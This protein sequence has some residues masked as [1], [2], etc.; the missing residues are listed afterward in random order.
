MTQAMKWRALRMFGG[1]LCW[2]VQMAE[3]RTQRAVQVEAMKWRALRIF[4]GF[5]CWAVQMAEAKTQRAVQV[6]EPKTR[7]AIRTAETM[8]TNRILLSWVVWVVW[9]YLQLVL[10][11]L[12]YLASSSS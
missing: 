6:A 3:A 1:F 12:R 9:N 8:M 10:G 11:H 2:A 5:L 4:G 7:R